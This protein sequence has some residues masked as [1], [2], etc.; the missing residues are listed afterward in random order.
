MKTFDLMRLC[1]DNLSRRKGRTILTVIGV[2]VGTCFIVLMI[3]LGVAMD[4]SQQQMLESMGDLSTIRVYNYSNTDA[5]PKLNDEMIAKIKA[6]PHVTV[7]S[8]VYQPQNL[9]A[10]LVGG[11]KDRYQMYLGGWGITAMYPEALDAMGLTLQSGEFLTA[12]EKNAKTIKVMFGQNA[13]Y[14]FSDSRSKRNNYRDPYPDQYGNILDPFLDVYKDKIQLKT[15]KNGDNDKQLV[16]DL[17]ITGVFV[18]DWAKADFTGYGV[19]MDISTAKR[20]ESEYMKAAGIKQTETEKNKGYTQAY[21]KVDSIDKVTEVEQQIKDLGY[22]TSSMESWRESMQESAKTVQIILGTIGA[23]ALLVAAINIINTMTM[24]IYER[25]KEIGVMKVLGCELGQIRKMFLIE[26]GVIG[27]IGGFLGVGFSYFTS[28]LINAFGPMLMGSSEGG[29]LGSVMGG[30]GQ[31]GT[32]SVIPPWLAILGLTFATLVGVL[33]G[34]MPANRAMR[35]SALEAIR[36][37]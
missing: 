4:I 24:A 30:L 37:Q 23:V 6:I 7:S 16:Y 33:S 17:E 35:I 27:F 19:F 22:E 21:V 14:Q 2:V 18:E 15:Q 11:K 3:S 12:E 26:A 1:L 36:Q 34:I 10:M 13:A 9:Q 32:I 31:G 20:L 29:M 25:T 8:P 28:W 5:V